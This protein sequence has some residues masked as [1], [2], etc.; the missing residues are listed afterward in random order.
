MNSLGSVSE[1]AIDTLTQWWVAGPP[2]CLPAR[3]HTPREHPPSPSNTTRDRSE[4][5][6]DEEQLLQI[7]S[8]LQ[9]PGDDLGK[10]ARKLGGE[11]GRR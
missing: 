6:Q 11:R 2:A 5:R 7:L 1:E 8:V 10:Q 3:P 4:R 9:K